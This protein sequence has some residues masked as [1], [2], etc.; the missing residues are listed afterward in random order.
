VLAAV[1][2]SRQV[3]LGAS[4]CR[5]ERCGRG[6]TNKGMFETPSRYLCISKCIDLFAALGPSTLWFE[7]TRKSPECTGSFLQHSLYSRIIIII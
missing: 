2:R 4:S 6:S 7:C 1:V 5:W 3:G